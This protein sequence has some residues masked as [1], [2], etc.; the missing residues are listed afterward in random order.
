M[1]P[2]GLV[3]A[4]TGRRANSAARQKSFSR[5][6]KRVDKQYPCQNC[7]SL[8]SFRQARQTI[9]PFVLVVVLVLDVLGFCGEKGIPV[10]I[11][12]DRSEGETSAFLEYEQEHEALSPTGSSYFQR[13]VSLQRRIRGV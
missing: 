13:P 10:M 9:C 7:D 8:A 12:F 4:R 1:E 2:S 6:I 5:C 11:L 3:C